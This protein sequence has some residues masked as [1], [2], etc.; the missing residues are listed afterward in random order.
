MNKMFKV[1]LQKPIKLENICRPWKNISK[2][3]KRRG[4]NK[5]VRAF[6]KAVRPGKE[7]HINQRRAYVNSGLQSDS[8]TR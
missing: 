3:N 1:M 2:F 7:F 6:N 8:K 5:A 4:F